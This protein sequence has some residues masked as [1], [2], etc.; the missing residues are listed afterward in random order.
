MNLVPGFLLLHRTGPANQPLEEVLTT[1]IKKGE[2]DGWK[3]EGG[4]EVGDWGGGG[5][6]G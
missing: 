2:V 1:K 4:V 6:L 3:E 5:R